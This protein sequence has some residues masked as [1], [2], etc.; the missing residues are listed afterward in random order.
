M[1]DNG[2]LLFKIRWKKADHSQDS[3]VTRDVV[4]DT[5]LY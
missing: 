5:P 1:A 4:E 3:W 2:D